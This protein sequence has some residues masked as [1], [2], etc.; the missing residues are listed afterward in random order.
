MKIQFNKHIGILGGMGPM[1]GA[2]IF[3]KIINL[4]QNYYGAVQDYEFPKITLLNFPLRGFDERGIVNKELVK[5]QLL[6]AV[7]S[8]ENSGCDFIIIA[9][10]TIH[11]FY[12]ALQN[13]VKIPIINLISIVSYEVADSQYAKV[14]LLTSS[15]TNDFKLYKNKLGKSGVISISANLEQQNLLDSV[16]YNV[17]SG[18]N[19]DND[20][21]IIRGI[22]NDMLLQGAEAIVLGCTELPL[23]IKQKDVNLKLFDANELLVKKALQQAFSNFGSNIVQS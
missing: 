20:T 4:A 6:C 21:K 8:L 1:A 12:E 23:V 3:L 10:N 11:Y 14:G 13:V 19:N 2:N 15:S 17:M 9:C 16:I 18:M 22:I 7:V 5:K